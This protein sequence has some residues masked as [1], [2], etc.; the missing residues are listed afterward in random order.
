MRFRIDGVLYDI[1]KPP[2]RF[3]PAIVS[4]V[5]IMAELNIAEKRLPQDGRIRT[6]IAGKDIDIRVSSIPTA[7]G[8]RIVMR[9]LDRS[10]TLLSL[11]ELGLAGQNLKTVRA[12]DPPEPRHRAGHRPDRQRQDDHALRGAARR[13]TRPSSNI[14]TI[15]DPIEYQLARH[16]PDAG[17]PQDRAH[18]R[19]RPALDPAPGP[20][21]HHGRRDPRRRD[22]RDRHPGGAHRAPGVLHAA[23]QRRARRRHAPGRHGHRAVPGL[24][25]GDR[26]DGAATGAPGVSRLPRAERAERRAARRDR[27]V[28]RAHRLRPDLP[29]RARL[30]AVQADRLPR[31][32]RHP[33]AADRRRRGSR[34]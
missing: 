13:S 31:P 16:Q 18:V 1:V 2:K 5:K 28:R 8:E 12:A 21:R 9:L 4:R 24:V 7:F 17:E 34:A 22:R 30:R 14:I 26:R 32:R 19:Q 23:H 20:G 29:S 3:Q 27:P 6:K 25:L 11:D 10:A 15:E 33:R